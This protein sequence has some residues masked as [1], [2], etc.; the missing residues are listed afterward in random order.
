MEAAR[1]FETLVSYHNTTPRDHNPEDLD[2]NFTVLLCLQEYKITCK[3]GVLYIISTFS[4]FKS[5]RDDS[6][7]WNEQCKQFLNSFLN[8]LTYSDGCGMSVHSD[9]AN[10]FMTVKRQMLRVETVYLLDSKCSTHIQRFCGTF[11]AFILKSLTRFYVGILRREQLLVCQLVTFV[12]TL[13]Y[14]YC[15]QIIK[16]LNIFI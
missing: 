4:V 6:S 15:S 3:I 8:P 11:A 16:I 2:L 14:W 7:F 13:F 12:I 10:H 1:S 5:K 9:D